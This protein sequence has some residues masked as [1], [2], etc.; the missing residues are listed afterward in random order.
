MIKTGE[1]KTA[2]SDWQA[3]LIKDRSGSLFS[4]SGVGTAITTIDELETFE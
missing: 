1:S 3:D 2:L 4:S